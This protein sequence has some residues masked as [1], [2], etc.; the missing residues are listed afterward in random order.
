MVY[1]YSHSLQWTMALETANKVVMMAKLANK[2]NHKNV[3][4]GADTVK[5]IAEY[6]ITIVCGALFILV[7]LYMKDKYYGIGESKYEMYKGIILPGLGIM[8]VLGILYLILIRE[9]INRQWIKKNLS[10]L[11]IFM[12]AYLLCVFISYA[13]CDYKEYAIWGYEGWSMGLVS[14][15]TF[16]ALYFFVSRFCK[17]GNALLVVLFGSSVI[18]FVLGVLN[19]F[20]I[21]PLGVYEGLGDYHILMFLST[22]GQS[23]W[24][25]SFMCVVLPAGLYFYWS[26]DKKL[27]KWLSG[28]FC[29]LGFAT[30][31][32]QNSDSAY[33]A[34]ICMLMVFFWFSVKEADKLF[35]FFM[36]TM[37]YLT[38][39]R[40][41]YI[42]TFLGNTHIIDQLDTLTLFWIK[43]N[44]MWVFLTINVII[45]LLI[46]F[47]PQ[48][49][50]YN[51]HIMVIIRNTVLVLLILGVLFAVLCLCM[52]GLDRLPD[53]LHQITRRI[54]YLQWNDDWGNKRGFTWRMTWKIFSEMNL[55]DKLFGVGPE[56]FA[57]YTFSRYRNEIETMFG[58]LILSNAHNEWYNNIINYGVM[59]AIVY[60]GAF[61]DSIRR[62]TK[63]QQLP[64]LVGAIACVLAYVGH[65]LFCYQQVLCTPFIICIMGFAEYRIRSLPA[66]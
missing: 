43:N 49:V 26:A 54:P 36:L 58:D 42:L 1:I 4:T 38:A 51:A 10:S 22:L 55:T 23:S 30:L 50:G 63:Y 32:T 2:Q 37:F 11:D 60:L 3:I 65:N 39:T 9:Q 25:S 57:Q 12:L 7:P 5:S 34:L 17:D 33:I 52:S 35:R 61:I 59:G 21:D 18:V 44:L 19:R 16:V 14:Q 64:L 41:I 40:I 27:T 13:L 66:Y 28:A 6:V 29:I 15:I 56:C 24:Y 20:L 8:A 46:K 45:L 53:G 47:L 31:V 48:K 62:F